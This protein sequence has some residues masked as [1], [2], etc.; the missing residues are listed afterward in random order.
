MGDRVNWGFVSDIGKPV[1]NLYGHWAG[2]DRESL[3]ANALEY[4]K[5]RW[6]DASYATRI[7]ISQIIGDQW[8]NETG[9]RLTADALSD[10]EYPYLM[11]FWELKK[12]IDIPITWNDTGESGFQTA[13]AKIPKATSYTFE[14]FIRKFATQRTLV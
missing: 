8:A 11:V 13:L 9:W 7:V 1:I 12:V 5:P 6:N 4:A 10:N 3:L 14:E 2:S